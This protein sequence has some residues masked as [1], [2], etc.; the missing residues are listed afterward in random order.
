MESLQD[1]HLF[2]RAKFEKKERRKRKLSERL[3]ENKKQMEQGKFK[4]N[5]VKPTNNLK[6]NLT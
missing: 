1:A 3:D 5:P 4:K 2:T 6:S